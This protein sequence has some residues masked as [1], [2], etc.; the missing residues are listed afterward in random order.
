MRDFRD[1]ARVPK[2]RRRFEKL[3]YLAAQ[4]GDADLVA[5]RLSC[6]IDPN[7]RFAMGRTPLIANVRGFSPS[8]ATVRALVAAGAGAG[9]LDQTGLTALDYARR[10]L[11]RLQAKSARHP[12]K[13]PSLDE[14]YQLHLSSA[15]QAELD[16]LRRQ[17][18]GDLDYLRM[19]WRTPARRPPHL[20]RS[21]ASGTDRGDARGDGSPEMSR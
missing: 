17:V 4:R 6:G 14:N 21:R 12:R 1:M 5:E 19:W 20:Q 3:L 8:V 16:E 18:D 13:S 11:A 2:Q 9:L 7:C 15:E 10:K